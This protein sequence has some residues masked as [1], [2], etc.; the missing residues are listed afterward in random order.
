VPVW[1]VF[2]RLTHWAVAALV[3]IELM[4]EAGANP[5]HRY[6]GYAAATLV[7]ARLAWGIMARGE[8]RLARMAGTA[9]EVRGYLRAPRPYVGHNP[10]G[11]LMAFA[12]WCFVLALGLT[13]WMTQLDAFWGDAWLQD[14][15]A[16]L[17]YALGGLAVVHIGGVL[18]T[19]ARYRVN[20]VRAMVTGNKR[21]SR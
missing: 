3:V 21:L 6:L 14:L 9:L 18:A 19:S 16:V 4:N 2:V 5:W 12:L 10:L 17:A 15:H 20:L 1:D 11:A 13:G 8:A 7:L